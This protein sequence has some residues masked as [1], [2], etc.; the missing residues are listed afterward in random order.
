LTFWSREKSDLK[1][2]KVKFDLISSSREFQ[3]EM[4][5]LWSNVRKNVREDNLP[6]SFLMCSV[7]PGEGC[8]TISLGLG[9]FAARYSGK[10]VVIVDTQ[11][12]LEYLDDF[13]A[14]YSPELLSEEEAGSQKLGFREYGLEQTDLSFIQ[15]INP[16]VL[17]NEE[18]N[19][20][21]FESFLTFLRTEYDYIIFDSSPA[22]SSPVTSFLAN[23][24]DHVI[25]IAS[26]TK[27]NHRKLAMA[28]NRLSCEKEKL[29]GV[30]M[31]RKQDAIPKFVQ[32]IIG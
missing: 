23:K 28:I 6:R 3:K 9:L 7:S 24:L 30:V 14:G 8:T 32:K 26:A 21:G 25:F 15:I 13:L 2:A 31:N 20:S 19:E 11:L 18:E 29:L 17:N 1:V 27:L 22:L 10:R 5:A 16:E 12:Q 4:S